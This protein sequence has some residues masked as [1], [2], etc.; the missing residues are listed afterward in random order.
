VAQLYPRALG[1]L[2][3]A[4]YDSQG[5]RWKY[6]NPPPHGVVWVCAEASTILRAVAANFFLT[7]GIWRSLRITAFGTY[8]GAST[9]MRK[10][11]DWKR[12]RISMLDVESEEIQILMYLRTRNCL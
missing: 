4:S 1:S 9:I 3:V 8:Q 11:F 5:L 2:S 12:S 6:S 7:V 10:A